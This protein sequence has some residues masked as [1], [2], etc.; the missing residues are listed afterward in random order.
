[1]IRLKSG[2]MGKLGL[3][4]KSKADVDGEDVKLV[5]MQKGMS[6][7]VV[8]LKSGFVCCLVASG[9]YIRR[10]VVDSDGV[11]SVFMPNGECMLKWFPWNRDIR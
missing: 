7:E 2:R 9:G 1:M 5:Y 3:Q 6:V 4:L 8:F 10:Q 11:N